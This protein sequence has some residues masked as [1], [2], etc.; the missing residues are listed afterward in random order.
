M[1]KTWRRQGQGLRDGPGAVLVCAMRSSKVRLHT[2]ARSELRSDKIEVSCM[3]EYCGSL[4]KYVVN[5]E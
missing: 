5:I 2:Q 3:L 1:R 4:R